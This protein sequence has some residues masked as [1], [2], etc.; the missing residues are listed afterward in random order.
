MSIWMPELVRS[1]LDD[2]KFAAWGKNQND[3]AGIQRV[4]TITK[5]ECLEVRKGGLPPLT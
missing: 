1:S 2:V 3:G 5:M 4:S